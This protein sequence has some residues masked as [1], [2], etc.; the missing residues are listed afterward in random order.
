MRHLFVLMLLTVLVIMVPA[1]AGHAQGP[2]ATP[3]PTI[4]PLFAEEEIQFTDG[5][6][7]LYGTLSLPNLPGK[8]P[9]ALIIAGSGPTNR[10]GDNPLIRGDVGTLRNIAN[11][12]AAAG[13]ASLRYD[14]IG[15]GKT[16]LASHATDASKVDFELYI[17]GALAAYNTLIARPEVDPTKTVIIG[18]SE[19]GLIALVLAERLK[20]KGQPAALVLATPIS[21]PYFD[22]L[23]RQITDQFAAAVKAG[24]FTQDQANTA[25]AELDAIIASLLEKGTPPATITFPAFVQ[26]FGN[27]VN[28]RFLAQA[29]KYDPRQ[30]VAGWAKPALLFCATLDVQV[31]CG[32]VEALR[33]AF[34]TANTGVQFVALKGV[35]HVLKEVTTPNE[36]PLEDY[37]NP[38]LPF[39]QEAASTLTAFVT[40]IFGQ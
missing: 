7:T 39:S 6:D 3:T 12:L 10:N 23:R 29:A 37:G 8:R 4:A 40:A 20:E 27:P 36:N 15:T 14:K 35:N 2:T 13:V 26:L 32:D 34:P 18:H 16:G 17:S 21:V 11:T 25:L 28:N 24:L 38:A 1:S 9:A 22:L 33:A 31:S 30:M 19:G 5:P